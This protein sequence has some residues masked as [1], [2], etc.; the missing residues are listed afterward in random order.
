M[1]PP[2]GDPLRAPVLRSLTTTRTAAH[3]SPSYLVTTHYL[4]KRSMQPLCSMLPAENADPEAAPKAIKAAHRVRS[5][6]GIAAGFSSSAPPCSAPAL[7][8]CG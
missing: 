4:E 1:T 6:A 8:S 3:H 2:R 7:Q 5:G